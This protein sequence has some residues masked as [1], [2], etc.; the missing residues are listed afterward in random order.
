MSV[1]R[2]LPAVALAGALA[3]AGCSSNNTT[4]T[5]SSTAGGTTPATAPGTAPGTT[6]KGNQADVVAWDK[7]MQEQLKAVGCYT[8]NVDGIVGPQTDA[9]ILAFQK[10]EGLEPDGEVG[11]ETEAALSAA[12]KSGKKVCTSAGTTTT[13]KPGTTTT[14]APNGPAPCTATALQAALGNATIVDY[15]CTEGWAAGLT[16]PASGSGTSSFILKSENGKWVVP[17][18]NPCGS[19]SAGLPPAILEMGCSTGTSTTTAT[20]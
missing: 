15:V 14:T 11:P 1:R 13:A 9:A 16:Q 7:S 18:Q 8:G 10:A 6:A 19:A 2:V 5:T 12:A 3:L 17:G 4:S 20:S